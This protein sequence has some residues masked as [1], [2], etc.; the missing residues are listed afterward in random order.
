MQASNFRSIQSNYGFFFEKKE[1]TE[2][3]CSW[4]FHKSSPTQS[5]FYCALL[6]CF[7]VTILNRFELF[8]RYT[9]PY[10]AL[11][12]NFVRQSE[13]IWL[14]LCVLLLVPHTLLDF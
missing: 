10:L 2:A 1:N 14:S 9:F 6:F 13:M 4:W 8:A 12:S 3:M 11:N 5:T 7:Q